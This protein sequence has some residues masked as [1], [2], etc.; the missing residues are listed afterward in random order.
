MVHTKKSALTVAMTLVFLTVMLTTSA[1]AQ[2]T[3]GTLTASSTDTPSVLTL[4]GS[5]FGTSATVNIGIY[6]NDQTTLAFALPDATTDDLGNFAV[7]ITLP[8]VSTSGFYL[9]I[10]NTTN[11]VGFQPWVLFSPSDASQTGPAGNVPET[12]KVSPDNSNIFNVTGQGFDVSKPV[13]IILAPP[14]GPA[15]YTFPPSQITTDSQGRFSAIVIVPTTIS[16][17]FNLVAST[18]NGNVISSANTTVTIPNLQGPIGLTG[19]TGA[20][21]APGNNET[22]GSTS[23]NTTL[24]YIS[25]ALSVVAIVIGIYAITK[26]KHRP[27]EEKTANE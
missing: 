18:A 19:A 23:T 5:G 21:G 9:I 11:V 4:T 22:S 13:T 27:Y 24:A 8:I 3:P 17:S 10:A 1:R 16:G 20:T 12:V 25:I 14:H 6:L 26:T 2:P 7:N 15:T